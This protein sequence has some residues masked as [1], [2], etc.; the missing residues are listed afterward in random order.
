MGW[1]C[2]WP[3]AAASVAGVLRAGYC[4]GVAYWV[5]PWPCSV[6]SLGWCLVWGSWWCG[7]CSVPWGTFGSWGFSFREFFGELTNSDP[8]H[9][10]IYC[11]RKKA[12]CESWHHTSTT[13]FQPSRHR[14]CRCKFLFNQSQSPRLAHAG[15]CQIG[16]VPWYTECLNFGFA[17]FLSFSLFCLVYC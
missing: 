17:L 2:P 11:R 13:R 12:L 5:G 7:G 3:W 16:M 4:S 10:F 14:P 15:A 9:I 8:L 1:W 6:G